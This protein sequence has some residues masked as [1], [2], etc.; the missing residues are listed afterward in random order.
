MTNCLWNCKECNKKVKNKERAFHS[1][2]NYDLCL[3]CHKVVDYDD[4][5]REYNLETKEYTNVYCLKDGGF[6]RDVNG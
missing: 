5:Y 3:D 4:Y 6:R 1:F 2:W